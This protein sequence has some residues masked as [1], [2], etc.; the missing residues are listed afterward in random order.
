MSAIDLR[1]IIEDY[2]ECVSN[3][4]KLKAIL[5]DLYPAAPKAILNTLCLTVHCGVAAE[6]KTVSEITPIEISRWQNTLETEYGL[7]RNIID[8][9]L[10]L[11]ISTFW[12]KSQDGQLIKKR[13]TYK[14]LSDFEISNDMHLK[15]YKGSN[16]EV[17]IPDY[18]TIIDAE[19]FARNEHV[20]SVTIPDSVTHV[21]DKAFLYC[22]YLKKIKLSKN[23][24][25]IGS[26]AFYGCE[27]LETIE[28]PDRLQKIFERAFSMCNS[29]KSIKLPEGIEIIAK[30]TFLGCAR[31]QKISIPKT[32][33][34]IDRWVFE[35]CDSL[36][37]I[38]YGGTISKW[39]SLANDIG[40]CANVVRVICSD[41]K[42]SYRGTNH[43]MYSYDYSRRN[44]FYNYDRGDNYGNEDDSCD[45]DVR[46]Y[47][48]EIEEFEKDYKKSMQR[49]GDS[50]WFYEDDNDSKIDF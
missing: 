27:N 11:W 41:G 38:S 9:S 24:E 1:T 14:D 39:N 16:A 21:N 7:T 45:F 25:V 22:K 48:R 33:T 26:D 3:G 13:Y 18:I 32:V 19:A 2:P 15:A 36:C 8:K 43:S 4:A 29:L 40:K 31:L 42:T 23:L 37:A 17:V 49:S 35:R 10:G 46:Q 5:S 28:L 47:Y 6:I 30:S 12:D 44:N 20:E 34:K 50:G